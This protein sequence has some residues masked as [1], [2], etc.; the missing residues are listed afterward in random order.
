MGYPIAPPMSTLAR[1]VATV[2]GRAAHSLFPSA[3]EATPVGG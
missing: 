3:L 2:F 1:A